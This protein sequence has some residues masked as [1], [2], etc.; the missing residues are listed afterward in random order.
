[1]ATANW[2]SVEVYHTRVSRPVAYLRKSRVTSDRHVSW[3]VQERE[4]RAL[5]THHGDADL[6]FLSDW[7][8]SG[9]GDKT[10]LRGDY[11]R[12]REMVA[13][14][15]VSVIYSYSLSR[16]ARSLREYAALA[17]DCRDHGVRIRLCKEGEFD[18]SSAS[19]RFNVGV[20]A[21]LAQMEA[22]LAQERAKDTIQARRARG[23]HV[24]SAGYG[25]RLV[26]GKIAEAP[27]E[28]LNRLIAAWR[29][30][31]TVVVHEPFWN[32]LARHADIVLPATTALERNDIGGGSRDN[33]LFA[34]PQAIPPVG[35]ARNDYDIFTG[36][37]ER[38]GVGEAFTEGRD[39][40]AWLRHLYDEFRQQ[41]NAFPDFD[42]FWRQGHIEYEDDPG[43]P[44]HKVLLADFRADPER[45][46]LATPSGRIELHSETIAGFGY[47]DCPPHPAWLEPY[48]WLG[49]PLAERYPLHLNSNQ[50]STRLHSQ[51]DHGPTSQAAKVKGR[52]PIRLH[53]EDAA[54]R[55]IQDG[56]LVRVFNDRGACL[57]G[58]VISDAVRP[59][60]VQLATGAW[61]DPV[62]PGRIGSLDAQGNPNVLTRDKGTSKLAQGPTAHT[63]LVEVECYG[64]EPPPVRAY[65]P[66]PIVRGDADG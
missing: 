10:R 43:A 8:K 53:P 40:A 62:E 44:S 18:Y 58:A 46:P 16:L 52:E 15:E 27:E 42:T 60:V 56:D 61:Y 65:D 59:G 20:L 33:F 26:R 28:D 29:R 55:G 45:H 14:D 23:D 63:T 13:A 7:G 21:L 9:R 4:V 34:M 64:G 19:G 22:D 66:P 37:A 5:A 24:G 17:E 32:P 35:Q 30:P 25:K 50:P 2:V 47:D 36:L 54:R 6:E 31:E 57:A 41:S 38:L 49:S 39:E 11:R 12:L 48:E 1:M 3:E 51:W